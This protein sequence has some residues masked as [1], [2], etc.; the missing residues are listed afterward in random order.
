MQK[1]K[2]ITHNGSFHTDDVFAVATLLIYLKNDAEVV[3]T[4]NPEIIKKIIL[5]LIG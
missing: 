4:R 1:K 3:R 5:E 2:L